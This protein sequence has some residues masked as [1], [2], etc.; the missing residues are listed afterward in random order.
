MRF[1]TIFGIIILTSIFFNIT[2]AQEIKVVALKGEAQ[3][4]NGMDVKSCSPGME[5]RGNEMLLLRGNAYVALVDQSGYTKEIRGEGRYDIAGE[6]GKRET[7]QTPAFRYADYLAAKLTPEGKKNRLSATGYFIS[8]RL[9]E[10]EMIRLFIPGAGKYYQNV[11]RL[12]WDSPMGAGPFKIEVYNMYREILRTEVTNE[13]II[14]LMIDEY[15]GQESILLLKI[16]TTDGAFT[17]ENYALKRVGSYHREDIGEELDELR[18]IYQGRNAVSR[19][20]MAGFFEYNNLLA[21]ALTCYLQAIE[22]APDVPVYREAYED[23][24]LRNHLVR[25]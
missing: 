22:Q 8:S 21:D 17:S 3:V 23:F 6:F 13:N 1:K 25:F 2:V 7:R 15:L 4:I 12:N 19:F 5:L 24:L 18:H 11:L 9:E 20:I 10:R 14:D 16:S